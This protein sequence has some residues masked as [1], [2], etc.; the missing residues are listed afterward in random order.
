MKERVKDTGWM[1]MKM[2]EK[3]KSERKEKKHA[4]TLQTHHTTR[5]QNNHTGGCGRKVEKSG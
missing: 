3:K 1:G 5:K 2:G 4:T